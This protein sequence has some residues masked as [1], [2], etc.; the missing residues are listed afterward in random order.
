MQMNLGIKP[1]L[2]VAFGFVLA[3]TLAASSI[4]LI[5]YK[6][7]SDSLQV[8]TKQSVPR[9]AE[10]M[11]LTQLAAEVGG[12]LPLLSH[13]LNA[14][15]AS[16]EHAAIT[17]AIDKS[18]ALLSAKIERG[19]DIV[20]SEQSLAELER[21]K[22]G[23]N[24]ALTLIEVKL[25]SAMQLDVAAS[26]ASEIFLSTDQKLLDIVNAATSRFMV[27]AEQMSTKNSAAI[28][29]LLDKYLE[30]MISALRLE[31]E[32]RKLADVL[33]ISLNY[34]TEKQLRTDSRVA[35]RLS[36]KIGR[37]IPKVDTSRIMKVDEYNAILA[38]IVE[39]AKGDASLYA[40]DRGPMT[41]L[42]REKARA[43]LQTIQKRM[44]LVITPMVDKSYFEAFLLGQELSQ[45]VKVEIP[46]LMGGGV[47]TLVALL[48]LR[49]ELNTLAGILAQVPNTESI[50][51]LAPLKSRF[52]DAVVAIGAVTGA[53]SSDDNMQQVLEGIEKIRLLASEPSGI[54]SLRENEL[55]QNLKFTAIEQSL[56]ELQNSTVTRLLDNV[57]SSKLE[58]DTAGEAVTEL[59]SKSQAQLIA[60][61][62]I[63]VLVTGLVFW[64]LVSRNIL[65][66][67]LKTIRALR[68]LADGEYD[69]VVD[70]SGA[71]ELS[72]L[73]R[74][75]EVF[76]R[77]GLEAAKLQEEQQAAAL[78]KEADKQARLDAE[79]RAQDERNENHRK[80]L[81][82]SALRE[83][84]ANALQSRVD[85]LLAAV[86]AA[87]KGNLNHPID[88]VGDDLA[89]QMGRALHLL[90]SELRASMVGISE[91]ASQLASA[92]DSL[93]SLSF[94]MSDTAA[95]NTQSAQQA[96]TLTQDV[97]S[98][99]DRVASAAEQMSASIK[100]IA[101]S[102]N[103]AELVAGEAVDLAKNT[104]ATVRK[105]A[106]S[107]AGIGSVIKVITSIAE[108][109][110]LLALNA[111]I[112]AARAGEAGKGFAVVA[113]EVKDL[114]KETA[115][116]TDQIELR[117][118]DIQNDTTSAVNA[119]ESI[120][121]IISKISAIQSSMTVAIDEQ[122]TVTQDI[123]RSIVKTAN[124]SEA[125]TSVIAG[126]A[127]KA[128]INQQASDE[129]GTAASDLS[130]TA[131]NLQRM[132][133]RFSEERAQ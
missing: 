112:E 85:A 51:D 113:N 83:E 79:Q 32:V 62:A 102:T 7:F 99:V 11:E 111:T 84:Q 96:S 100:E 132:V 114:A 48:Q 39:L 123:S 37:L 104:D 93:N 23:A 36:G 16:D 29:S 9:M 80:E 115:K 20:E 28:D 66:R 120:S 45:Q 43:E 122:A 17:V 53:V 91:N 24:E 63:S 71:D 110:N 101:R 70:S 108:Q 64:F 90:F 125:I 21:Q 106:E 4:A 27:A 82:Q 12:R 56:L 126:V 13:S 124:G 30:P 18:A 65:A 88:T 8:I 130:D 129:I 78:V 74:T 67:L 103:E 2:L 127:E 3:T 107:S 109:T 25:N 49:A 5:A 15:Q 95:S 58:V 98:G 6:Q 77:R 128:M 44:I 73:A 35:K 41:Q 26:Q 116:A 87:S 33:L 119:I 92:S 72:A 14:Q 89:G 40:P 117:I 105:L 47:G 55:S 38:R 61:S 19:V 46:E 118:S 34:R 52:S 133:R 22:A 76:R 75:V 10:S 50:A 1:K 59:I 121:G 81:A 31:A 69:V 54:F 94:E 97:G 86:S 57:R 68:S 60:V 131:T 42:E